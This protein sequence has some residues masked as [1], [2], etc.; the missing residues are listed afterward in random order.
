MEIN[1]L[2]QKLSS[3]VDDQYKKP[4]TMS[5]AQIS[6][7]D[8][9]K[10]DSQKILEVAED[11]SKRSQHDNIHSVIKELYK[12]SESDA[13]SIDTPKIKNMIYRACC[14][15]EKK[16]FEDLKTRN[17]APR[18]V[19]C[20]IN[21]VN[22]LYESQRGYDRRVEVSKLLYE[23]K[24]LGN[25]K[26][27]P[28]INNHSR[29][30]VRKINKWKPIYKRTPDIVAKNKNYLESKRKENMA[31]QEEEEEKQWKLLQSKRVDAHT[32]EKRK[33]SKQCQQYYTETVVQGLKAK[34]LKLKEKKE[35][36]H[37]QLP[38]IPHIN[39]RGRKQNKGEFGERL[40]SHSEKREEKLNQLINVSLKTHSFKPNINKHSKKVLERSARRKN[41]SRNKDLYHLHNS[42]ER[43]S[44][45]IQSYST[46]DDKVREF[47]KD[48]GEKTLDTRS[49]SKRMEY[50]TKNSEDTFSSGNFTLPQKFDD[51][52]GFIDS[53][54]ASLSKA[55]LVEEKYGTKQTVYEPTQ[56]VTESQEVSNYYER[57]PDQVEPN[58]QNT[59]DGHYGDINE[60]YQ[61]S[62]FNEEAPKES[63]NSKSEEDQDHTSKYHSRIEDGKSGPI[64]NITVSDNSRINP[65][66]NEGQRQDESGQKFFHD[67]IPNQPKEQVDKVEGIENLSQHEEIHQIFENFNNEINEEIKQNSSQDPR[68]KQS[69][70]ESK[71]SI[72][73]EINEQ[74]SDLSVQNKKIVQDF[75]NEMFDNYADQESSKSQTSIPSLHHKGTEK[76]SKRASFTPMSKI[77][78]LR[79]LVS[80]L[81][82]RRASHAPGQH[83][84]SFSSQSK[85]QKKVLKSK[86]SRH[87][88]KEE[89]VVENLEKEPSLKE[90]GF[91][92]ISVEEHKKLL[93]QAKKLEDLIQGNFEANQILP[94]QHDEVSRRLDNDENSKLNITQSSHTQSLQHNNSV[95]EKVCKIESK[96]TLRPEHH[97]AG[98]R[99]RMSQPNFP[100]EA[101]KKADLRRSK[102]ETNS[103]RS[104]SKSKNKQ[105]IDKSGT[106]KGS[107]K[108]KTGKSHQVSAKGQPSVPMVDNQRLQ[109]LIKAQELSAQPQDKML[110]LQDQDE[111]MK[112]LSEEE[113]IEQQKKKSALFKT[114][115]RKSRDS[116]TEKCEL[117]EERVRSIIK[118][119]NDDHSEKS[120]QKRK[121][122]GNLL[123]YAMSETRSARE[124][125]EINGS[126]RSFKIPPEI[127]DELEKLGF[128][129]LKILGAVMDQFSYLFVQKKKKK[130]HRKKVI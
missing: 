64:L 67:E 91:I 49:D 88:H 16:K 37:P 70:E 50:M 20:H 94:S 92:K 63:E 75:L 53:Y 102:L 1:E 13:K 40:Y 52:K 21:T 129:T 55:I 54:E 57:N 60:N 31:K 28:R 113:A 124:G 17:Q 62:R 18:S 22:R 41:T 112:L 45:W 86:T 108:A 71:E 126:E 85:E 125:S 109:D 100:P 99:K 38:G 43:A 25:N 105:K 58:A 107:K 90:D 10:N 23:Q 42:V 93:E 8:I 121:L 111:L 118:N 128:D 9:L 14:S 96:S 11:S 104:G 117:L 51:F 123:N 34:E 95:N 44:N 79:D 4:Q 87:N 130:N 77:E 56:E 68:D 103:K 35:I 65:I 69:L 106:Q 119:E 101:H 46:S 73:E 6:L 15:R 116:W 33:N 82:N 26:Q 2:I 36:Y 80:Q 76:N 83:I 97:P 120:I 115:E 29:S 19:R 12:E 47:I 110:P 3:F 39:K 127:L 98:S 114:E 78:T 24:I 30:I 84:D 48:W 5:Q 61:T 122:L 27:R 81:Q 59:K 7:E 89:I 66:H 72:M 32:K 74:I